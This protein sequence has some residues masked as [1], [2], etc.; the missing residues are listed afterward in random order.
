[1]ARE[2][3]TAS[4]PSAVRRHFPPL[5]SAPVFSPVPSGTLDTWL[6]P[7]D[8]IVLDI[9]G[10]WELEHEFLDVSFVT[11]VLDRHSPITDCRLYLRSYICD[12]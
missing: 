8:T 11:M 5:M 10:V 3:E 2:G 9:G 4:L 7:P 1:M 6:E 12:L